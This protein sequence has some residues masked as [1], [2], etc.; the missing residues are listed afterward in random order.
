ME[1]FLLGHHL[2]LVT[3]TSMRLKHAAL[4]C[5]ST[6]E[7]ESIPQPCF[8]TDTMTNL[9]NGHPEGYWLVYLLLG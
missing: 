6:F 2:T 7:K 9:G 5:D 4:A 8:E 3:L 1:V